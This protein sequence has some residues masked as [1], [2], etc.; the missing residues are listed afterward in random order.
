MPAPRGS[1]QED[2]PDVQAAL[3][4]SMGQV[5]LGLGLPAVAAPLLEQSLDVRQRLHGEASLEVAEARRLLG[6]ARADAGDLD[7]AEKETIHALDLATAQLGPNAPPVAEI[8]QQLSRIRWLKGDYAGGD[9]V[10]ARA[11]AIYRQLGIDGPALGVALLSQAS[12]QFYFNRV[13]EAETLLREAL[14]LTRNAYGPGDRRVADVMNNLGHILTSQGKF[15][16]ARPLVDSALSVYRRL[17]G[18]RHQAVGIASTALGQLLQ[19]QRELARAETLFRDAFTIFRERF[20][21]DNLFTVGAMKNLASIL[22]DRGSCNDAEPIA[23]EA[24]DIGSRIS[25]PDWAIAE[26]RSVLGKCQVVRGRYAEAE[27]MLLESYTVIANS[28]GGLSATA[29][30][31]HI[32][33]LYERSGQPA[34]AAE[35]RALMERRQ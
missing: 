12:V 19:E 8:L 24:L 25:R 9:T 29:A 20:G 14:V 16:E 10:G 35:Y 27:P 18:N 23:R 2:Q 1:A 22:A 13:T 30:L 33:M 34:K 32:V 11:I 6:L 7:T 5:Y 21:K 26:I 3:M 15:A 17:L 28:V 31:R 4:G